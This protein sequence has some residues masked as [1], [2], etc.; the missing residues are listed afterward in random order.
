MAR[1]AP[2]TIADGIATGS[3]YELTFPALRDGLAG[4]TLVSDDEI[5]V[6]ARAIIRCTHNLVEPAGAAGLAGVVKLGEELSGQ[7]V[8]VVLSG[9]NI[10]E[11]MLKKVLQ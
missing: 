1:I 3:V 8:C 6:A 4:F 2:H 11:A 9:G 5:V 7:S 10:D